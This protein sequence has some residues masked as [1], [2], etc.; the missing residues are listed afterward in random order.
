MTEENSLGIEAKLESLKRIPAFADVEFEARSVNGV[1]YLISPALNA[2]SVMVGISD[3]IEVGEYVYIY[4]EHYGFHLD[5]M[6]LICSDIVY[7]ETFNYLDLFS[8]SGDQIG[9]IQLNH[10]LLP[11]SSLR[12]FRGL[13]HD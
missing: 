5:G 9:R 7:N 8:K 3:L 2:N 6:E 11:D 10:H 12:G 13:E 4:D 1:K